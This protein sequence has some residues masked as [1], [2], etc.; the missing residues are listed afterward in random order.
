MNTRLTASCIAMGVVACSNLAAQ[1]PETKREY[2]SNTI[3]GFNVVLVVGEKGRSGATPTGDL[4]E[5]AARALNDMREFLPYKSYRVLDAQWSSCCSPKST[6]I[7]T[8]RLR[9]VVGTT[10]GDGSVNPRHYTFSVAASAST[11]NLPIRFVLTAEEPGRATPADHPSD[12]TLPFL[13]AQAETMALRIKEMQKR[14]EV[15]TAAAIDVRP[16]QDQH[17]HLKRKIA[18]LEKIAHLD[19]EAQA[20]SFSSRPI[21]NSSFT[22]DASET[23]VVGTSKLGGD[24]A[25]IAI[26]TAVRKGSK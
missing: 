15:G 26:V 13:Q 3:S 16:L 17:E 25:L 23:V 2:V 11:L 21:I 20:T 12:Q 18:D 22:M 4:P 14:V 7:V 10:G 8:G 19:A 1:A 5:G 9:G 6:T 24:K